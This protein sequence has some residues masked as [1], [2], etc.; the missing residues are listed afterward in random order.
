MLLS[1]PPHVQQ[2]SLCDE[3]CLSICTLEGGREVLLESLLEGDK[4]LPLGAGPV[5]EEHRILNRYHSPLKSGCTGCDRE[6]AHVVGAHL[7]H[8]AHGHL[9]PLLVPAVWR[10]QQIDLRS[11]FTS[12]LH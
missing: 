12:D 10:P 2:T 7:E 11:E 3:R 8:G 5:L 4:G 9:E 6:N 1:P